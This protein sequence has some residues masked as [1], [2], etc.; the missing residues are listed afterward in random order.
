MISIPTVEDRKGFLS[1]VESENLIPFAIKRL[2]YIYQTPKNAHRGGHA[3]RLEHEFIIALSGSFE[4]FL[5]DGEKEKNFILD[6]PG[7]GLY[8]PSLIWVD[9]HNLSQ[10]SIILVAASTLYDPKDYIYDMKKLIALRDQEKSS[11]HEDSIS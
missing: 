5:S 4:I 11:A 2:F 8:I 10:N 9:L 3:H 6:N 7:T 1:F